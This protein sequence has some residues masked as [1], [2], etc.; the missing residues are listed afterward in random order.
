MKKNTFEL[1]KGACSFI[2]GLGVSTIAGLVCGAVYTPKLKGLNK[3]LYWVGT[4]VIGGMAGE[5]ASE[6]TEKKF[7]ELRP[8]VCEESE[9]DPEKEFEA[10]TAL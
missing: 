3:A 10:V 8:V 7:E 4:F 2:S 5:A 9:K 6:Y 1:V